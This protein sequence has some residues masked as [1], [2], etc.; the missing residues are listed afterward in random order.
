MLPFLVSRMF[1][2][3]V[4]LLLF[5]A[6]S[7]DSPPF[8]QIRHKP[9]IWMHLWVYISV[10][11][12]PMV[13]RADHYQCVETKARIVVSPWPGCE[14]GLNERP[15]LCQRL[16]PED[17]GWLALTSGI[18]FV[19]AKFC[20]GYPP[21][22]MAGITRLVY[23]HCTSSDLWNW[24]ALVHRVASLTRSDICFWKSAA[25]SSLFHLTVSFGLSVSVVNKTLNGSI[26]EVP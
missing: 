8:I 11:G 19:T 22:E 12:P 2:W 23:L 1:I 6:K 9:L 13:I 20:R 24:A 4:N 10:G 7:M 14:I 17:S 16:N 18:Q 15:P 26:Q 3:E 21:A 5:F 25:H